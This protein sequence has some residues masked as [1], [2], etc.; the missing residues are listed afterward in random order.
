[1]EAKGKLNRR[2]LRLTVYGRGSELLKANQD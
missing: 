2:D 1:V